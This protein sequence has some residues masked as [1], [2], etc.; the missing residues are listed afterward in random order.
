M[1]KMSKENNR[2]SHLKHRLVGNSNKNDL[3]YEDL[4]ELCDQT[5]KQVFNELLKF[6]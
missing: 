6:R 1:L 4:S 2:F 5:N 3:N